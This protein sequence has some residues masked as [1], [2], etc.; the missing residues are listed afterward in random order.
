MPI[1]ASLPR[2]GRR[3]L[4]RTRNG[5]ECLSKFDG[6]D[7]IC[8]SIQL[9]SIQLDRVIVTQ[10]NGNATAGK[11]SGRRDEHSRDYARTRARAPDWWIASMNRQEQSRKVKPRAS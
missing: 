11:T 9:D 2:R 4:Q 8:P 3:D 10:C 7:R 6:A 1:A 5:K